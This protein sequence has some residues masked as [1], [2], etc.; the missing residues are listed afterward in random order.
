M[1]SGFS[2]RKGQ[3]CIASGR[4]QSFSKL[5]REERKEGPAV[6]GPQKM[7]DELSEESSPLRHS[8]AEEVG[9]GGVL[10]CNRNLVEDA[11]CG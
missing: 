7:R 2:N 11:E 10:K 8:A 6:V 3:E 5:G 9:V 1:Y 4:G